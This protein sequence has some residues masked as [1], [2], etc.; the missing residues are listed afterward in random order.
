MLIEPV[1]LLPPPRR[2]ADA[3]AYR[4]IAGADAAI[5]QAD[6]R[7]R[8][9]TASHLKQARRQPEQA[10]F[11]GSGLAGQRPAHDPGSRLGIPGLSWDVLRTLHAF[12]DQRGLHIDRHGMAAAAYDRVAA[13]SRSL[14]QVVDLSV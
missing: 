14:L 11:D 8:P 4:A 9:E 1:A 6:A 3:Y 5:T 10:D 13:Q 2:S 12:A 7:S